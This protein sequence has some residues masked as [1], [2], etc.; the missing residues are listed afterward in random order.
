MHF[1]CVYAIFKNE[2]HIMKE[3]LDHY[4]TEGVDHFYLI[5]NG[6]TDNYEDILKSYS[7][8]IT[9]FHDNEKGHKIQGKIYQRNVFTKFKET[10]WMICVDFDE[11]MYTKT[12]TLRSELE[13]AEYI[14]VGQIMVPWKMFGSS[15]HIK[16]PSSV[17]KSFLYR[18]QLPFHCFGNYKTI[19][20][21][22]AIE[23]IDGVHWY[24][25]VKD[26]YRTIK[27]S[28]Q[29]SLT[30]DAQNNLPFQLNHYIV[31]SWEWYKNTKMTRGDSN[32]ETNHRTEESFKEWD[33]NDILDDELSIKHSSWFMIF[34]FVIFIFILLY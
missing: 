23:E 33:N 15:G 29:S 19:C 27:Y 22:E 25:H 11:F 28:E 3:W 7:D 2:S 10:I 32:F 26:G 30:E 1:L 8:R 20:R 14:D 9:L 6:S 16:Q 12:G 24:E 5:D 34:I 31:Q 4:I 18:K 13:K 17:I 21:T